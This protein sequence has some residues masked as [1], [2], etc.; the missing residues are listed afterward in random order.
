MGAVS[1]PEAVKRRRREAPDVRQD[2][3][4]D[5]AESVLLD[6]GLAAT[7]VAD[8]ADAA[9]IA[10]GTVY[11]YFGSKAELLAGIRARYIERFGAQ[12]TAA[13]SESRRKP[14]SRLDRFVEEFFE[15]S[16]AHQRLHHILFHEAGFSEEDAFA[17]VR[18]VLTEFIR[19]GIDSG[20]FRKG[21]VELTTD[22]LL[23]GIHGALVSALHDDDQRERQ[24][25]GA[26]EL[27]RRLVAG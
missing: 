4:L 6:R 25:A 11:L 2:Q 8:V 7:T 16:H 14:V 10:K 22:F 24:T 15:Y 18:S 5:A 19:A 17:G 20:A 23:A 3:I 13:L 1:P 12:L 21:D 27:A 9:G 26:R